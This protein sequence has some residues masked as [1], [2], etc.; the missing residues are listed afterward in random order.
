VWKIVDKRIEDVRNED[1]VWLKLVLEDA[2]KHRRELIV[3]PDTF[4]NAIVGQVWR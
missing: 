4:Q 2:E 1:G 3:G